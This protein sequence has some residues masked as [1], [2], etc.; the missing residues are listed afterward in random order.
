MKPGCIAALLTAVAWTL[1]LATPSE[2]A[3]FNCNYAKLPA[4]VAICQNPGLG[5]LDEQMAQ[6]YF[7]IIN[8]APIWAVSQIKSQQTSWLARRNA[9]GYDDYC[10]STAYQQRIG[11]LYGWQNRL[12]Y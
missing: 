4:E 2:A 1:Q 6:L 11:V 8:Y 5:E 12:G 9:C 7:G 3:S 10:L